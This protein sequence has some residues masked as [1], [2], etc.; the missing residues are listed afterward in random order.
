MSDPRAPGRGASTEIEFASPSPARVVEGIGGADGQAIRG[1]VRIA[2]GVLIELIELTVRDIPG[3]VGFQ[4]RGRVE[5][6]LPRGVGV[7]AGISHET[8]DER[9]A[10][11]EDRGVRVRVEGDRIDADVSI[12]VEGEASIPSLSRRLRREV[13]VAVGRMLGMTVGEVNVFV[14]NIDDSPD[15]P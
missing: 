12:V 1:T 8:A 3:V 13:G 2:P 6:I 14:A 11:F 4:P 5:R 15:A 9:G 7:G 10:V